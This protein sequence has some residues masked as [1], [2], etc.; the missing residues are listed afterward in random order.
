[1]EPVSQVHLSLQKSGE[2]AA[3]ETARA[4]ILDLASKQRSGE[5]AAFETARAKILDLASKRAGGRLP[6]EAMEGNSFSIDDIGPRR[7]EGVS[8]NS[9]RYWALR[10][11]DDDKKVAGRSWV[12]EIALAE[13]NS[14][15]P[16]LFGLR[17]Q[18]ITRGEYSSYNPSIP[19]FVRGVISVCHALLDG[20]KVEPTPWFVDSDV[21]QLVELLRAESR[22]AD[23]IVISLPEDSKELSDALIDSSRLAHDL[24]GAAHVAV[25]SGPAAFRLSEHIGREFS[26]FQQA[27]RTYRPGFDPDT[28]SPFAHPLGLAE[29]IRNW[30]GGRKAYRR[31]ITSNVLR[32]TVESANAFKLLPTFAETKRTAAELRRQNAQKAGSSQDDLLEFYKEENKQLKKDLE[33]KDQEYSDLLKISEDDR[34]TEKINCQ[35]LQDINHNLEKRIRSLEVKDSEA[36]PP[37]PDDLNE[38]KQWA[39]TYLAGRVK[40][41]NR[42]LRGAKGSKYKN[43]SMIYQ[44]LLLLGDYYVPMRRQGGKELKERYDRRCHELGIKEH[45]SFAGKRAGEQGDTYFIKMGQKRIELDRHLKRG[46]GRDPRN[47]F[48]L[49]FCWDDATSQVVVGW[50][51]SHLGHGLVEWS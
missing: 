38:L 34:D 42:A 35:C 17:L 20:R 7:I 6:Q 51:P 4:K 41:H 11:D 13:P 39:T 9:P 46:K 40:L 31:F 15:E 50:L 30:K 3:F 32:R 1:V 33:E 21:D 10:F 16:V 48:R 29:S 25:I 37:I 18:C 45:A 2:A 49:Y 8:I 27:V 5:A 47:C 23:V 12:I 14:E 36:G 26:V 19:N 44:A 28:E 22:K 43:I 24:A